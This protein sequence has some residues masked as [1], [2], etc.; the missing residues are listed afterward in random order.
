M[1]TVQERPRGA[2]ADVAFEVE[3]VEWPGDRVEITGRWFGVRGLR[4]IRPTLDVEVDGEPRRLLALLDHKPWAA[5]DGQDWVAAFPWQGESASLK[6]AELTVAPD[7][8]VDLVP[9]PKTKR[10]KPRTARRSRTNALERELAEARTH[11]ERLTRDLE[12]VNQAQVRELNRRDA[13]QAT[14]LERI[15]AEH[16]AAVERLEAEHAAAVERLETA[17]AAELERAR[18]EGAVAAA[19]AERRAQALGRELAGAAERAEKLAAE[20]D[21]AKRELDRARHERA[22]A[23]PEPDRAPT[24]ALPAQPEGDAATLRRIRPGL[25]RWEPATSGSQLAARALAFAAL[26]GLLL[27]L[28]LLIAPAL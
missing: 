5:E 6:G 10:E 4:F 1:A 2:T 11:V 24:R 14:E 28:A 17:K 8:G 16:S 15:G 9:E 19:D 7:L 22:E 20:R 23:A 26:L 27:A 21:A 18:D 3:R 13:E 12:R 25:Y